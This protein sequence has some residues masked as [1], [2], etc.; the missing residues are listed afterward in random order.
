MGWMLSSAVLTLTVIVLRCALRGRIS[1]RTQYA[2]W[3]LVLVRLLIPVSFGASSLS[4][5]NALPERVQVVRSDTKPLDGGTEATPAA[6]VQDAAGPASPDSTRSSQPDAMPAAAA[7]AGGRTAVRWETL[8]GAVWLAGTAAVGTVFLAAN[9][10]FYGTLR[11]SRRKIECPGAGLPVYES[12]AIETPCL[13]GLF[14]PAVYITPEAAADG[15]T[16]RY[17]LAHERTHCRHGDH[18]WAL[19]RGACLAL[20]WW[21]PLV[22]WA[23]E[24]SRRDA[25]LA[26][27]EDAVR[28]LGEHERAA[29][30]R[31]LIRMTC[32]KRAAP[33]LT[34]TMM[35]DSGRGLRERIALLVKRPKTTARAAFAVLAVLSLSAAC[36]F[37]GGT[38]GAP[39]EPGAVREE[40]GRAGGILLPDAEPYAP[41]NNMEPDTVS[42]D[43][44]GKVLC[45]ETMP[46]GTRIVCYWEPR[47]EYTK[48]WAVRRGDTLLRFCAE[49]SAYG[50]EYGAEPF[51]N[52][53]GQD[54]FRIL[55]PRG[56]GYFAYDY[57]VL[58]GEGVPRLLAG[59]A[60]HVEEADFNGDGETD[61]RWF[62][63][64]GREITTCF[65]YDGGLYTS[66]AY[67]PTFETDRYLAA[68]GSAVRLTLLA[69][70]GAVDGS[71]DL[72][73][74]AY[75]LN[76]LEEL[77]C[78]PLETAYAGSGRTIRLWLAGQED[79]YF[80]FY[81]GTDVVGYF[82]GLGEGYYEAADV[83]DE[84][85]DAQIREARATWGYD[86]AGFAVQADTA[87]LYGQ[88][89]T[90]YD[91]M[92]FRALCEQA[93]STPVPDRGQ[94]WQEAAQEWM[95]A[96][97]E[98]HLSVPSGS[99]EK[100]TWVKNVI[101][102]KDDV[103]EL[104]RQ[105]G[106]IDENVYCFGLTVVFV[107]EN[108]L[109]LVYNMAGNTDAYGDPN[110][111]YPVFEDAEVPDGA[112]IY[113]RQCRITREADGWHGSIEGTGG[114]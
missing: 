7:P 68:Y 24:L 21:G 49:D 97:Q 52:V 89:L 45:D 95:D 28:G 85:L 72:P 91:E 65:R 102:P 61:L 59:C 12:R 23:A 77:T 90:W 4:V 74:G 57:Y 78:T 100:F 96:Y 87:T 5:M 73:E 98:V 67:T 84:L 105:Q 48:Y 9:L 6:P 110:N 34:A 86:P 101:T 62:Y 71:M 53:L 41:A 83:K 112:Y 31:T 54:G 94:T 88:V 10:H 29:Y 51:S 3:L 46:D 16:L 56:A 32:E 15:E 93:E 55:G 113:S 27:D 1:P 22:W 92:A 11:R 58:D 69:D 44:M 75:G 26:C 18:L 106:E 20:H 42:A 19:L 76:L 39:A 64:G 111:G 108:E 109:A 80:E 13:F 107:P 82:G 66:P 38:S 114:Y 8:A 35:T 33:L 14:R 17:A 79:S 25:E 43:A 47:S 30:G 103:T 2:L 104:L 99:P 36:T 37:T 50:G 70:S 81:E 60:N 40:A 63:H